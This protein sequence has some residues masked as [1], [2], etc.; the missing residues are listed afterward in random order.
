MNGMGP[1]IL[2]GVVAILVYLAT[3]PGARKGRKE[4]QVDRDDDHEPAPEAR[5]SGRAAFVRADV[6]K[7][8]RTDRADILRSIGST[9]RDAGA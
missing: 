2:A 8:L 9:E 7:R 3:L 6:S 5:P 1:V 4:L